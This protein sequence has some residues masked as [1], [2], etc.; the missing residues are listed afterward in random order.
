G[1]K[2]ISMAAAVDRLSLA[3][4]KELSNDPTEDPLAGEAE[5]EVCQ[6]AAELA[7]EE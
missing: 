3:S 2:L 6:K 5:L 7:V 1:K 4:K